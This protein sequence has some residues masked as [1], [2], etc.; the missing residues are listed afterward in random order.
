MKRTITLILFLII[1]F[2]LPV[3][4]QSIEYTLKAAFIEKF[5]RFIKWPDSVAIDDTTK[6]FILSVIGKN[7][8]G[9]ALNEFFSNQK[10]KNKKVEIK[11]ISNINDIS[12]CHFLFISESEKNSLSEILL[13]T[14]DKPILT[15]SDT[16]G[17]A[18]KGVGI[19]FVTKKD[20]IKFEINFKTFLDKGIKVNFQLLTLATVIYN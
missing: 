6:V 14:K 20:K 18:E 12:E 8:F 3:K 2:N 5:T 17:F 9:I 4:G 16:P 10:I 13:F 15:V 11:Y 19:N 7:P 1:S